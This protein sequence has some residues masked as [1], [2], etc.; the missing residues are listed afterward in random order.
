MTTFTRDFHAMSMDTGPYS[1][2]NVMKTIRTFLMRELGHSIA[3]ANGA[4]PRC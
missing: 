3:T 2:R 1:F 4:C